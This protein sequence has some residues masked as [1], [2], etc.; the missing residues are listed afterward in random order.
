MPKETELRPEVDTG[1]DAVQKERRGLRSQA[2]LFRALG[3]ESRLVILAHLAR[4]E[5]CVCDLSE[6]PG[7]DLPRFDE[8]RYYTEDEIRK[9]NDRLRD[10]RIEW[11]HSFK[12]LD[13]EI[14]EIF[15]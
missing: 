10:E 11:L 2:R 5:Y 9:L 13:P 3:H 7:L 15:G 4:G 12:D 6:V 14:R 8:H 1:S